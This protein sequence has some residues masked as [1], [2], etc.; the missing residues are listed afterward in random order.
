MKIIIYKKSLTL[1]VNNLSVYCLPFSI[2]SYAFGGNWDN[3]R[4]MYNS[5]IVVGNFV[6]YLQKKALY[7]YT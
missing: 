3:G 1:L 5:G 6:D 2:S 7:V 4:D